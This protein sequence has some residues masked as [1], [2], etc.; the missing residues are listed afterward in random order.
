M[1]NWITENPV[2]FAAICTVI[3]V[4]ISSATAMHIE[5]KRG[6]NKIILKMENENAKLLEENQLLK[7]ELEKIRSV[8]EKEKTIDKSK[9]SVYIETL[10]N[11]QVREI[12]GFCW[13]TSKK[14]VPIDTFPDD[15]DYGRD[16]FHD[17]G[18]CKVCKAY[19]RIENG[20]DPA[21]S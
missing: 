1:L 4:I 2:I 9:G 3:G 17:Y 19:C 6:L 8:E 7:K 10:S 5:R 20:F 12:C 18:Q 15:S 11:N 13:E 16:F 14:T 21:K